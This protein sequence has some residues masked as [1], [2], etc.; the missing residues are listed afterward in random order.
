M[1][2]NF[3]GKDIQ[4]NEKS[5]QQLR[6][7]N[8]S[9][10]SKANSIDIGQHFRKHRYTYMFMTITALFIIAYTPR[11]TLNVL[12]TLKPNFWEKPSA[13]ISGAFDVDDVL[14]PRSC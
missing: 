4:T 9:S 10:T 2:F 3:S 6:G 14:F 8:T 11:V 13:E 5:N 12:E 7:N 1:Y